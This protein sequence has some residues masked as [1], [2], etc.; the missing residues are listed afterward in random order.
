MSW[1]CRTCLAQVSTFFT[2]V[3]SLDPLNY[4]IPQK[5]KII[6]K[7][8]ER[9]EDGVERWD[10]QQ[11]RVMERDKRGEGKGMRQTQQRCLGGGD[12]GGPKT[13]RLS[14]PRAPGL[15]RQK[16]S[17][18]CRP[19]APLA[20]CQT[21]GLV[22]VLLSIMW[23]GKSTV[24]SSHRIPDVHLLCDLTQTICLFWAFSLKQKHKFK[25]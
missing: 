18:E 16:S 25:S 24:V 8:E 15:W 1:A 7:T 17:L 13:S 12:N 14:E 4:S 21:V 3:L 11:G 23:N 5:I 6:P 2:L 10:Q 20:S 9:T 19:V 22:S